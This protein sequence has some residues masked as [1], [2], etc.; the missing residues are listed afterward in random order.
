[1]KNANRWGFWSL[2]ALILATPLAAQTPT[3]NHALLLGAYGGGYEPVADLAGQTAYF[4]SGTGYGGTLGF[5]LSP[6]WAL[7]ADFTY[8]RS[9][10]E[11]NATFAGMMFDKYFYGIHAELGYPMGKWTPYLFFGGGAVTIHETGPDAALTSFTRP[12]GMFGAGTFVSLSR[13]FGLFAELKNLIYNWDRGGPN[14]VVWVIPTT[15]G[16][17][18]PVESQP[19]GFNTMQWDFT[20]TAGVSYRIP[21]GKRHA[22]THTPSDE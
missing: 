12:A 11:G 3:W 20:Y 17:N 14:P 16:Q 7:H 18:Y 2:A 4:V 22:P 13:H 6:N 19:A 5:E 1:M 9:Q 8:T 15:G 10:A 21:L